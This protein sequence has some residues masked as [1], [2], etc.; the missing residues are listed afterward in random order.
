MPDTPKQPDLLKMT[1]GDGGGAAVEALASGTPLRFDLAARCS[2]TH[3]RAGLLV[4]PHGIVPTP[5]FMPVGTHATV[6]AV[7]PDDLVAIGSATQ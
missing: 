4:T 6:K 7:G 3:A 2:Q 1:T 5:V